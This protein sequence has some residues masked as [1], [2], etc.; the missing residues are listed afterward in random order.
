MVHAKSAQTS[1]LM[2]PQYTH[3]LTPNYYPML[4]Y[5]PMLTP[6]HENDWLTSKISRFNV[7]MYDQNAHNNSNSGSRGSGP[8][9]SRLKVW[10]GASI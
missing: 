8:T 9:S 5:R 10:K 4:K 3:E 2:S 7:A 1:R 6:S